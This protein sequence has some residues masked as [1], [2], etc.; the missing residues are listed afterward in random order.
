MN[1]V[2]EIKNQ[3]INNNLLKISDKERYT[4][5]EDNVDYKNFISNNW[6]SSSNNNEILKEIYEKGGALW[7][8]KKGYF[9]FR[10]QQNEEFVEIEQS[11]RLERLISIYLNK[12]SMKLFKINDDISPSDFKIVKDEF[13]PFSSSEF[14][15]KDK[16]WYRTSF[17]PNRYL[18]G[19]YEADSNN[20]SSILSL[21]GNLTNCKPEREKWVINWL[22]GFFQTLKRSRVSLVLRGEQG[23]GKGIFFNEVVSKLFGEE[24]CVVVGNENLESDFKTWVD[25]KLFYNLNEIA[26]DIKSRRNIKNFLKEM[27]TDE[28]VYTQ[29]K[30]KDFKKVKLFGNILITSNEA[31]PIEVEI[32]DR[33]FTIFQTGKSLKSIEVD[34]NKLV[35]NIRK[36]LPAFADYLKKYNV[37]WIL[38][39]TALETPEKQAIVDGTTSSIRRFSHAIITHEIGFFEDLNNLENIEE[40]QTYQSL[41]NAFTE[42]KIERSLLYKAYIQLY[43]NGKTVKKFTLD[44]RN[45]DPENFAKNKLNKSG[46]KFYY[47][48]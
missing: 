28:F 7:V 12:T 11:S 40:L 18:M 31:F 27:V 6:L 20:C 1:N 44:L 14:Y 8:S 23:S 47:K 16:K 3:N 42:G 17:K 5:N 33:R 13:T 4:Y 48:I 38:Y 21:I 35:S 24:Y 39:H 25:E 26:I 32:S 10:E 36:E 2:I 37:D 43:D 41:L 45:I 9:C 19:D 34:T 15:Y 22:A 29:S 30:F 46:N